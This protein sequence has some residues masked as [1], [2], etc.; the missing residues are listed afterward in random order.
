MQRSLLVVAAAG[1]LSLGAA[2]SAWAVTWSISS[3]SANG[4]SQSVTSLTAGSLALNVDT[5]GFGP[6]SVSDPAG[7]QSVL[8][9][10]FGNFAGPIGPGQIGFFG[11]VDSGGSGSTY[12]GFAW[13][14]NPFAPPAET[15]TFSSSNSNNLKGVITNVTGATATGGSFTPGLDSGNPQNNFYYYLFAGVS[16]P[17]TISISGTV[18]NQGALW[19]D[20]SGSAWT[21][22]PNAGGASTGS[23]GA[24]AL[25]SAVLAGAVPG[26]GASLAAASV[27]AGM[28]SRRRVRNS[29]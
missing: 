7:V 27:L 25:G 18:A 12:F 13:F 24:F 17:S 11:L 4:S 10:T 29:T 19:L 5:S 22:Y 16:S 20:W 2:S 14:A 26:G 23:G 15:L 8:W 21:P 9:A 6:G 3:A 28:L 1:S